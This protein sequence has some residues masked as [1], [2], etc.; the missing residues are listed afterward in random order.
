MKLPNRRAF[1]RGLMRYSALAALGVFAGANFYK[2]RKGLSGQECI[3]GRGVLACGQCARLKGCS[4]PRAIS[5]K[6]HFDAGKAD[7]G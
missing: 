5:C 7:E 6:N 3:D 1:F 2:R 4:L